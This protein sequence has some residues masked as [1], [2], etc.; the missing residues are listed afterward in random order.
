MNMGLHVLYAIREVQEVLL[1]NTSV[2][3]MLIFSST[4]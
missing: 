2:L 4:I 3:N 1:N